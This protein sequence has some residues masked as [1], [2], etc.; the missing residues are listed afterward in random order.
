MANAPAYIFQYP[1]E[2]QTLPEYSAH[3]GAPVIVLRPLTRAEYDYQGEGM[4]LIRA[5]D[6]WEGHAF[7]SELTRCAAGGAACSQ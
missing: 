4:Y 1:N 3:R 2:F 5:A 6:G 7:R